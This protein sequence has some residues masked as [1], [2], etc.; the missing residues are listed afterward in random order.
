MRLNCY[1]LAAVGFLV[2]LLL[3]VVGLALAQSHPYPVMPTYSPLTL[4]SG[5]EEL[6]SRNWGSSNNI[7]QIGL[8]KTFSNLETCMATPEQIQRRRT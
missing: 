1:S 7:A 4:S 2:F 8:G 6:A 3:F 5:Y